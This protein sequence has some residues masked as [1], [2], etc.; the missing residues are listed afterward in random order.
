MAGLSLVTKPPVEPVTLQEA[1]DHLRVDHSDE[2]ALIDQIV[3]AARE[4]TE[5]HTARAFLTQTWDWKLDGFVA[6]LRVPKPPLQSVTHIKYIDGAGV[7]QTLDSS[8][9]Q[10]AATGTPGLVVEAHGKSWPSARRQRD[11]VTLRFVAGYGGGIGD[12]PAPVKQAMLLVIGHLYLRREETISGTIITTIPMGAD[13]L[14][15]PY[16]AWTF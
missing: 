12:V 9:Y 7:E 15:A 2:D 8:V 3:L 4:L 14:L 6:E 16:V 5:K 1:K 13:A 11:A 10:V